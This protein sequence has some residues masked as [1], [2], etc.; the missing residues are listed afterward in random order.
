MSVLDIGA[1]LGY[2]RLMTDHS[3][4]QRMVGMNVSM[5]ESLRQYVQSRITEGF[6]S[7]SEYVRSLIRQDQQRRAHERT[8]SVLTEGL[9]SGEFDAALVN[10]AFAELR[11]LRSELQAQGVSLTPE[12]IRGAIDE[13]RR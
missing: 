8:E 9:A 2:R 4:E 10:E 3:T 11:M 1:I 5:P 13:G 12:E 7:V 6:G